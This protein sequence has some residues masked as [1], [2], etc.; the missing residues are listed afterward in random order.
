M[1]DSYRSGIGVMLFNQRGDVLMGERRNVQN[2]WQMPQGGIDGDET[3]EQALYR[4]AQEEIGTTNWKILATSKDWLYHDFP[5]A[6]A[7][8]WF[9]GKYLGQKQKWFLLE[10]LGQDSDI[11]VQTEKPEFVNWKWV[12]IDDLERI[13]VDFKK[14]LYSLIIREFK[15]LIPK[16]F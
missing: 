6:S 3:P 16:I 5:E 1:T 9:N 15:P 7:K 12:K 11:N 14:P 8:V 13:V 4:E 2:A 10:F